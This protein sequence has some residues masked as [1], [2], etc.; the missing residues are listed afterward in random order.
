MNL[1]AYLA[2]ERGRAVLLAKAVGT[3]PAFIAH[4]AHG[5]KLAPIKTAQAIELATDGEVTRYDLRPDVYGMP[6]LRKKP[7][8]DEPE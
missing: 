5:R 3:S 2:A 4:I 6:P 8:Q 1:K 7:E